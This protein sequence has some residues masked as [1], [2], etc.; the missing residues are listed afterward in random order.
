MAYTHEIRS[1]QGTGPLEYAFVLVLVAAFAAVA[2]FLIGYL[3]SSPFHRTG[4]CLTSSVCT[5]SGGQ[6]TG[7]AA[8]HHGD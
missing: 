5:T 3:T 1:T 2:V 4:S 8:G 6:P 7:S